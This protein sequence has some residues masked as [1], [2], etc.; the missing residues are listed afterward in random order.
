M[1]RKAALVPTGDPVPVEYVPVEPIPHRDGYR[2]GLRGPQVP[3]DWPM[4]Y[5]DHLAQ[6]ATMWRAAKEAGISVK[7]VERL[8]AA[9]PRFADDERD[10]I[11]EHTEQLEERLDSIGE[12]KDMPAV[13]S[14][15]VRLK[16][17]DPPGYVEKNLSMSVS[18]TGEL[19]T[20]DGK[21]L[22]LAMLG[23]GQTP[24]LPQET[25]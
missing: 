16:K 10:A 14:L 20:E 1:P 22:L 21:H 15:I 19:P 23:Q 24:Q 2:A 18:L 8:R 5:L 6:H 9:D 17:L 13:T 7:T 12:G 25:P 4:R 11:R 3:R